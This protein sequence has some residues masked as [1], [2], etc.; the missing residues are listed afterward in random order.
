MSTLVRNLITS[1]LRHALCIG[2]TYYLLL[3]FTYFINQCPDSILGGVQN[4]QIDE[5]TRYKINAE[6]R[7]C[8][9]RTI[10]HLIYLIRCMY[11]IYFTIMIQCM[12]IAHVYTVVIKNRDIIKFHTSYFRILIYFKKNENVRNYSFHLL[13]K[14]V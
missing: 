5:S 11:S 6:N 4:L 1:A 14:M 13:H 8:N 10:G 7:F 12:L 3:L 9:Y 2:C